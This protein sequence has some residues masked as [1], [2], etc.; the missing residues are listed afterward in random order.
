MARLNT[1]VSSSQIIGDNRSWTHSPAVTNS[2]S[3]TTC[4]Q[5]PAQNGQ[6][7]AMTHCNPSVLPPLPNQYQP[8]KVKNAPSHMGSPPGV[9]LPPPSHTDTSHR[10]PQGALPLSPFPCL[11]MHLCQVQGLVV[12]SRCCTSEQM[13]SVLTGGQSLWMSPPSL[14]NPQ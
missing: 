3:Q 7:R 14:F 1:Q 6:D 13:A 4:L 11:P 9:N 2:G 8:A 12:A 10:V 5:R